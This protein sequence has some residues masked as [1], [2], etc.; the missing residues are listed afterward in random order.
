MAKAAVKS[1]QAKG[2]LLLSVVNS[3]TKISKVK[4]KQKHQ[5]NMHHAQYGDEMCPTVATRMKVRQVRIVAMV[6][7]M[8]TGWATEWKSMATIAEKKTWS[9]FGSEGNAGF[10]NSSWKMKAW[11]FEQSIVGLSEQFMASV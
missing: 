5:V 2:N 10:V 11:R 7:N 1:S 4:K 3:R 6:R 8:P 9:P